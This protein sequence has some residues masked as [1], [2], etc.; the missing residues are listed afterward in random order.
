[1]TLVTQKI[2]GIAL[3]VHTVSKYKMKTNKP[4]DLLETKKK[5]IQICCIKRNSYSTVNKYRVSLLNM[6]FLI[7]FV[8]LY[9]WKKNLAPISLPCSVYLLNILIFYQNRAVIFTFNTICTEKH[10]ICMHLKS[11]SRFWKNLTCGKVSCY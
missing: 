6:T 5:K 7:C 10:H 4:L 9:N 1:M 3:G 8:I 2:Y 11:F